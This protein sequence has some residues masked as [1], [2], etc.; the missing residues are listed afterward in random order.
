MVPRNVT[1]RRGLFLRGLSR[2]GFYRDRSRRHFCNH[3]IEESG[4]SFRFLFVTFAVPVW[5]LSMAGLANHLR[6]TA[7]DHSSDGM[8]KQKP[9]ARAVV[10]N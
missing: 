5:V 7:V 10:V 2:A 8:V 3:L 9:A 6:H 1:S 4:A